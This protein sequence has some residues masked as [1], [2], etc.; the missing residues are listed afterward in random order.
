[1]NKRAAIK[2]LLFMLL[3]LVVKVSLAETY[4]QK[5]ESSGLLSWTVE[6]KGFYIELVQLLPDFIRAIYESHNFPKKEVERI[7]GY[8]VFGTII[9][10]T[11][12]QNITYNVANWRYKPKVKNTQSSKPLPVKTKMQ[13][14]GEWKKED[15][16]F[17][18]TLLPGTG[19]FYEGDWQ[20]GFTTIKLPRE[21]AFDFIYKWQLAGVPH[22]GII[23]NMRCAPETLPN[24]LIETN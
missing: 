14:L 23:K 10:N 22:T 3:F 19:E 15:I 6:E 18:W 12:K 4:V 8:C 7:A 11:S 5:N 21:A 17:S 20:Q 24:I 9:K 2:I 13:W 1:M 16:V